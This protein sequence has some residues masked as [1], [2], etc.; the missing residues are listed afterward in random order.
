MSKHYKMIAVLAGLV[1]VLGLVPFSAG[2]QTNPNAGVEDK[3]RSGFSDVPAMIGIAKCESG[4]RQFNAN[5]SVLRASGRY[6]GIFQIDE[7]IHVPRAKSMAYDIYTVDGNIAY[8][9]YLYSVSGTNP[10]K[11]CLG[12]SAPV[13]APSPTSTAPANATQTGSITINLRIG[14]THGQVLALQRLL[15]KTGFQ[16]SAS[17]PGSPGMETSTFGA[18]TREAVRKFQCAKGIVCSGTEGT[19]G[20]GHVGPRTRAALNAL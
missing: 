5:G 10:W 9:R 1:M 19:T 20:Y 4:F 6:I 16:L 17:G 7:T 14:M 3:V 8:A 11:G 13:P 12:T 2:A 18:L 15:N